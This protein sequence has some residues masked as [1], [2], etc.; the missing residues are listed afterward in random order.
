MIGSL[1]L[2]ILI[3]SIIFLHIFFSNSEAIIAP[4][5]ESA[6]RPMGP[7]MANPATLGNSKLPNH[8][9]DATSIA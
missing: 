6:A 9:P 7:S 1:S 8:A 4:T 2:S 5:V 3:A